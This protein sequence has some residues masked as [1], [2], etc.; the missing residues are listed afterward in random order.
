MGAFELSDAS[1][2]RTAAGCTIKLDQEPIAEYLTSN[3]TMLK[4]MIAEGY[5]D[6]R[7]LKRRIASMQAWL[8]NPHLMEADAAATYHTTFDIDLSTITEPILC[9]P[10]DPDDA[11][12]L[13]DIGEEKIDEVFI[14][15]CMTNIGH[16]R[17]A[18]ELLKAYDAQLPT[19]LWLLL[20]RRW[21]RRS[22]LLRASTAFMG[23]WGPGRRCQVVR[24]AW[25]TRHEWLRS[26]LWCQPPRA[27]SRT[28]LAK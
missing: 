6:A 8:A 24:S 25:G 26:R 19:R 10:N 13:S 28:V 21:T 14:G 12:K 7:T 2:E 17:A 3:I 18:G 22:S 23:R 1:A 15:S 5:G 11:K 27:T 20:R 9:C 16:F 4:W